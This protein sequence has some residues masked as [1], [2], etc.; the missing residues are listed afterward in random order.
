M[1]SGNVP[2]DKALSFQG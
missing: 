2:Q 1:E